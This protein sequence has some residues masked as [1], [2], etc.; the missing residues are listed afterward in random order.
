M[1]QEDKKLYLTKELKTRLLVS[2]SRSCID[3]NKFPEISKKI[4]KVGFK[5]DF[6]LCATDKEPLNEQ[7]DRK[8]PLK[9]DLKSR[10]LIAVSKGY[11]DPDEFPEIRTVINQGKTGYWFL[12]YTPEADEI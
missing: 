12:P 8:L 7:V 3:L 4:Q 10:L 1:D 9:K 6:P 5:F 11:I 2:M